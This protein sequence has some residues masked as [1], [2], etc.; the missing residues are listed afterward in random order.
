MHYDLKTNLYHGDGSPRR[1]FHRSDGTFPRGLNH[2]RIA[3][4]DPTSVDTRRLPLDTLHLQPALEVQNSL[5]QFGVD[6]GLQSSRYC[7][8]ENIWK[9]EE[10]MESHKCNESEVKGRVQAGPVTRRQVDSENWVLARC[11]SPNQNWWNDHLTD[12][13][14]ALQA[15]NGAYIATGAGDGDHSGTIVR[16]FAELCLDDQGVKRFMGAIVRDF[17]QKGGRKAKVLHLE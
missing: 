8:C 6:K 17:A 10:D 7:R 4:P 16:D 15:T 14:I 11:V 2:N 13:E 9:D 1:T 3:E 5:V 12:E